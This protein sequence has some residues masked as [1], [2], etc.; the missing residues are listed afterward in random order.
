MP[1]IRLLTSVVGGAVEGAAG[2][3]VEVDKAT[4]KVWAD[5]IRAELVSPVKGGKAVIEPEQP[6]ATD[7]EPT[8]TETPRDSRPPVE[9]ERAVAPP[10]GERR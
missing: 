7:A 10:A 6:E 2:D 4:A 9:A 3:I 8:E 5:G 1:A